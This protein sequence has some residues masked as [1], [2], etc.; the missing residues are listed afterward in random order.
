MKRRRDNGPLPRRLRSL[1][2]KLGLEQ[3]EVAA[4]LGVD[5][6]LVSHWETGA[7]RPRVETLPALTAL[8]KTTVSALVVGVN[9]PEVKTLLRMR[10]A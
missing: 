7:R 8:Y 5:K 2:D 9:W 6:T 10:A 4:R 1:R 3:H